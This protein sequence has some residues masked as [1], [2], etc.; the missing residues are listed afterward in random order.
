[1][2]QNLQEGEE[3][4]TEINAEQFVDIEYENNDVDTDRGIMRDKCFNLIF[5]NC[6]VSLSESDFI[7]LLNK[8]TEKRYDKF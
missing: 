5:K 2:C 1:M 6:V 8:I 7:K 3:E 4:I